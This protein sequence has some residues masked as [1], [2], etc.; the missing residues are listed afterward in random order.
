M[1]LPKNGSVVIIDDKIEEAFPLMN[2]LAKRGVHILIM[3][4]RVRTIRRKHWIM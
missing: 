1:D 4:A 3:M 2:A